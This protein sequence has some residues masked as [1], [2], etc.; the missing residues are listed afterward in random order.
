[1][2]FAIFIYHEIPKYL[3]TWKIAVIILRI[4]QYSSTIE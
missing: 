3:D 2:L 1:M 4:E